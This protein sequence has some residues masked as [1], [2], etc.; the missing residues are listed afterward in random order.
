MANYYVSPTGDDGDSGAIGEPFLTIAHACSV[1]GPGDQLFLRAATYDEPIHESMFAA[2][3][4][5][6]APILVAAF[7][8]EVVILQPTAECAVVR[9]DGSPVRDHI[10]IRGLKLDQ[11]AATCT[12]EKVVAVDPANTGIRIDGCEIINGADAAVSIAGPNFLERCSIHDNAGHGGEITGPARAVNNEIYENGGSGL[13]VDGADAEVFNNTIVAN[14]SHGVEI[15]PAAT[16]PRVINNILWDNGG[17][18]IDGAQVL[19]LAGGGELELVS[20]GPLLLASSGAS[21]N[22]IVDP[23]FVDEGGNDYR[24][25]VSSPAK[26]TGFDLTSEGVIDDLLGTPRPVDTFFDIGAYEF[27]TDSAPAPDEGVGEIEVA[28]EVAAVGLLTD[29]EGAGEIEAAAEV[30]GV[31]EV[32]STVGDGEIPVAVDMVGRAQI[33]VAAVAENP[34]T[35]LLRTREARIGANGIVEFDLVREDLSI[36]DSVSQNPLIGSGGQG[37]APA[38]TNP[39][40]DH[41]DNSRPGSTRL[42]M[43]DIPQL[44]AGHDGPGFYAAASGISPGWNG[45]LLF[46]KEGSE[47]IEVAQ[48]GDRAIIGRVSDQLPSGSVTVFDED[49]R[50]FVFDETSTL[51]VTLIDEESTLTSVSDADLLAGVNAA[52]VGVHGRWEIL[53][54]GTVEQLGARRYRLSHLLRGLKGTEWAV[55]LHRAGDIFVVLDSSLRRVNDEFG[56]LDVQRSFR[57][58]SIGTPFDSA[59]NVSFTNTGV[60]LKPLSPV[61]I[62]GEEDPAENRVIHWWRR[63]RLDGL[64]GRDGTADP[65]LGEASERYEVDVMDGDDVVRTL[66]ATQQ[67]VNYSAAQMTTDFGSVPST[68]TVCIYQISETRGRG[69]EGCA[70]ISVFDEIDAVPIGEGLTVEEDDGEPSV[71]DVKKIIFAAGFNVTDNADGSVTID[72]GAGSGGSAAVNV[73][74]RPYMN[75]PPASLRATLDTRNARPVLDFDGSADEEAVFSA[76][77]PD[78]YGGG[79]LTVSTWWSFTSA[80]SGNLRVQAAIERCNLAGLDIDSDSFAS[81]NSAGGTAPSNSGQVHKIDILFADGS[82]MDGLLAGE[83]FRLKIRRDADGTSGTDDI[84]TDAELVMV[85]ITETPP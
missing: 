2:S 29:N 26:D 9:F 57:A 25:Q 72:G 53:A 45:A 21:H 80:T 66:G 60:S 7:G 51:D 83:V 46:K 12:T 67:R 15:D 59:N 13:F 50:E 81:F 56:D 68:L 79:G 54:F 62:R 85:R 10:T 48:L 65:P 70:T 22:L 49:G 20:G 1:L 32:A 75:E 18:P 41:S 84:T 4:T 52:V 23:L 76:V 64:A 43:L 6:L 37:G 19:G 16:N 69:Y 39:D 55:P 33:T 58:V 36:Y 82:E 31:G 11:S 17:D 3:G 5:S 35:Y 14:T 34:K 47:Y 8:S 24:L 27:F 73:I 42:V 44:T 40:E 63:S 61:F 78:G 28:V 74:F 71:E 30:V 38:P 77:L